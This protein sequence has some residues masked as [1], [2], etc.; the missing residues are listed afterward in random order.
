MSS[1][2]SQKLNASVSRSVHQYPNGQERSLGLSIIW[3]LVDWWLMCVGR[4]QEAF[5]EKELIVADR[6]MV[7]TQ[8][9]E[10]L[11]GADTGHVSL[12]VVGDPLG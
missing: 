3:L 5:Y 11:A 12:L 6:D 4:I 7:E 10:I 2:G 9:D 8:S 1:V